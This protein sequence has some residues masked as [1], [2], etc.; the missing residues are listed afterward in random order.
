MA[1]ESWV[2][3]KADI[4]DVKNKLDQIAGKS[5]LTGNTMAVN[6]MGVATKI[7]SALGIAFSTRAII[8]FAEQSTNAFADVEVST[9]ILAN[10]LKNI[11]VSPSGI[12]S[13]EDLVNQLEQTKYFNLTEINE[14]FGNAAIKL[15]DIDIATKTVTTSMEIARARNI[16]L[17]DAIQRLTLGL[18]GNSRGL[19]DLGINIKDYTTGTSGASDGSLDLAT[20]LKILDSVMD[21]VGGSTEKFG[22]TT[23][24]S[25]AKATS[26]WQ[27]FKIAV[28]DALKP[29]T[30]FKTKHITS[31]L[32]KLND[33]L[34]EYNKA[35]EEGGKYESFRGTI[36]FSKSVDFN[37]VTSQTV[38]VI[39]DL[40]NGLRG[41]KDETMGATSEAQKFKA[42]WASIKIEG[43]NVP[44]LTK[45]IGNL[46]MAV[47]IPKIPT[48][49]LNVKAN[50]EVPKIPPIIT[51]KAIPPMKIDLGGTININIGGRGAIEQGIAKEVKQGI[52]TGVQQGVKESLP[53]ISH[54][55]GWY[56]N[57]IGGP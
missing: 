54:G 57:K 30:E 40:K 44:E 41:I 46:N 39:T 36:D 47:T 20:Q 10:I 22:E 55:V 37:R 38:Q 12:K 28:G 3:L 45:F 32:G 27:N 13:V 52:A 11:G 53:S 15:R 7:G 6:W 16:S 25:L 56:S 49:T 4:E 21:V 1:E 35:R 51:P 42:S 8:N 24:A 2:I 33:K 18:M 34:N 50:V 23:K 48:Q 17:S 26:A 31:E 14:A 19:R 9:M 29:L 43:M 5:T